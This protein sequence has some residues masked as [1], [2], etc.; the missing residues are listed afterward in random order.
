VSAHVPQQDGSGRALGVVDDGISP[1]DALYGLELVDRA[2]G[3]VRARVRVD[4]R[5]EQPLGLVHGGVYA[6]IAESIASTGTT[7]LVGP[8]GLMALGMSNNTSFLR[9][10]TH[11]H[12]HATAFLR[13]R[14]RTTCVWDVH[15]SDDDGR[16]C[17]LSKLTIA[18]RPL[19]P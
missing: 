9:P 1:F 19:R 18:V 14:G 15:M 8:D 13:H 11:G 7:D 3:R 2:A 4:R 16:L 6:A 17:A 10:I 12:I 5:L